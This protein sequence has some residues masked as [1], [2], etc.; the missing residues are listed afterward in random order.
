MTYETFLVVKAAV[1]ALAILA[2]AWL[3]LHYPIGD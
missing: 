2:G 3:L 1:E